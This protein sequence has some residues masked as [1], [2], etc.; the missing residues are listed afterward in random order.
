MSD[1]ETAL[2]ADDIFDAVD[3]ILVRIEIPEWQKG[4]KPGVLFIRQLPAYVHLEMRK[5]VSA[6]PDDGMFLMVA[7]ACCDAQGIPVFTSDQIEKL[8]QKSWNVLDRLQR[9]CLF[10]NK[11]GKDPD[12]KEVSPLPLD[13]Q[14]KNDSGGAATGAS[15]SS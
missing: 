14:R 6:T 1:V 3:Q 7:A 10:V 5:K 15:L 2:T 8:K 12:V 11:M 9:K 13:D 4:G